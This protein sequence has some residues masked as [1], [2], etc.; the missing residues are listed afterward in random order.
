MAWKE[1]GSI[2][3]TWENKGQGKKMRDLWSR[4]ATP[5]SLGDCIIK[6]KESFG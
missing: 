2:V 5:R 4:F 6:T 3:I 1:C